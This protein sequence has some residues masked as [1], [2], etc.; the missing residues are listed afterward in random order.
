[1]YRFTHRDGRVYE[2]ASAWFSQNPALGDVVMNQLKQE[3]FLW[4]IA[5][6]VIEHSMP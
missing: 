5:F 4:E 1:M 3:G 6:G 2:A